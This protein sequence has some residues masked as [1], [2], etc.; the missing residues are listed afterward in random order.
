MTV[1]VRRIRN[2]EGFTVVE[3]VMVIVVLGILAG[4][5]VLALGGSTTSATDSVNDANAKQCRIAQAGYKTNPPSN[6]GLEFSEY[7]DGGGPP[8]GCTAPTP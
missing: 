8:S 6:G 7:F 1:R 4:I 2:A 3:L 5:V